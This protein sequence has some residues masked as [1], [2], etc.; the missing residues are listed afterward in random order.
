MPSPFP[1]M[2][3]FLEG[4]LWVDVHQAL[5]NKIRETLAPQIKPKYVARLEVRVVEDESVEAAIGVM[6]PDVQVLK[7]R[8]ARESVALYHAQPQTK[9]RT[10]TRV[11]APKVDASNIVAPLTLALRD[12]YRQVNVQVRDAGSNKLVT[13]IEILSPANK[14]EPGLSAYREKW[15]RLYKSGVHLLEIDLLRRGA[16]LAIYDD[17]HRACYQVA[18]ARAKAHKLEIWPLTLQDCLPV[19]PVPLRKPDPAVAIDLQEIFKAVY[20]IAAY[21]LTIDYRAEPPPP[22]LSPQDKKWVREL[23]KTSRTTS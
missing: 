13:S 10:V 9:R 3:P 17:L 1:G 19:V 20:D 14:R 21:D 4:Y 5:A 2:D 6:Y 18:L 15:H 12:E 7:T 22:K 8:R 16:R 23:L 11:D